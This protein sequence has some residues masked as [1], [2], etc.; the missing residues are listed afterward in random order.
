M[1]APVAFEDLSFP[2]QTLKVV[3][4]FEAQ[5]WMRAG[6]Q[7]NTTHFEY[8]TASIR[9]GDN[10]SGGAQ[11]NGGA[12][13]PNGKIYSPG[14][15]RNEW[16]VVDTNND[17]TYVTG[18]VSGLSSEG[19]VVSK[20]T[21][22][23]FAYGDQNTKI[24]YLTDEVTA[25]S[26]PGQRQT[27][28]ILS[29]DGNIIYGGSFFGISGVYAYDIATN[30]YTQSWNSGNTNGEFGTLGINGKIFLAK[31][32]TGEFQVWDPFTNTGTGFG[33]G[34]PGDYS[35]IMQHYDGYIYAFPNFSNSYIQ[36]IDPY[37]LEVQEYFNYGSG[38]IG[39]G[40]ACIGADGRFYGV[41]TGNI[42]W[43][44][45]N[46]KQTGSIVTESGDSSFQGVTLG[47]NGD[48]YF[49]P[50]GAPYVHKLPL[51]RGSGYAQKIIQE[52]NQS[53][54]WTWPG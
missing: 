2:Q 9:I 19:C 8:A 29:Y 46:T 40:N 21:N 45:P 37:T 34:A 5:Q 42:F 12:L 53:S 17:T 51:V 30:T 52:F 54:R 48:L 6:Q 50:W 18:S 28:P 7:F 16:L 22:E 20:I 47:V 13:A 11:F 49:L 27:N 3:G 15:T 44:D 35:T 31:G 39:W 4:N 36:R 25:I 32:S 23:V 1:F 26:G 10:Y 41:G 24:N 43:F 38:D 33:S 14:H